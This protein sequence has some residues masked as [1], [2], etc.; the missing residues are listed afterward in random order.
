MQTKSTAKYEKRIKEL[1]LQC[2]LKTKE[3]YEAWMSLTAT[4]EQ[5]QTVQ[6]ELDKVTFK[7]LSLG[8]FL[9]CFSSK[10]SMQIIVF[11]I[12][13]LNAVNDIDLYI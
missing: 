1:T 6:M 10:K 9:L 11:E 12:H 4:N 5:L 3:C 13:T 2:Q 8:M 7:T